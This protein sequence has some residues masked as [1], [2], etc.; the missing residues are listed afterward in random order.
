[1]AQHT[2]DLS[3]GHRGTA[4][5]FNAAADD[6]H[7]GYRRATVLATS[8]GQLAYPGFIPS[9]VQSPE[10]PHNPTG[11]S[12]KPTATENVGE[13]SSQSLQPAPAPST[14]TP[15]PA[16]L[17]Q[18][19]NRPAPTRSWQTEAPPPGSSRPLLF[20][21]LTRRTGTSYLNKAIWE[22]YSVRRDSASS[23]SS[24]GEED[25][26]GDGKR[27][28]ADQESR[29]DKWERLPLARAD[30]NKYRQ[31]SVGDNNYQTRGKV[32][33]DGRLRITV[34]ETANTGYLAKA[35]GAAM[36][37]VAPVSENDTSVPEI[38]LTDDAGNSSKPM[39]PPSIGPRPCLNIVIMVIGSRG[40]AQPFLKIGKVLK[41]EYGHRVRI[42][43]HPAFRDFV[44]KDSGLEF[45]SVGGDPSELMAF[46]VKNPGLIPTIDSVKAGD[47]GKRRAA[48][49]EMFGGF[50]RACIN[51]TDDEKDPHNLKMMGIKTPFVADAII[52][53]PP[54]FAHIHCAE[55]LGI[56]LHLMFTFPYTPTQAFPHPLASV[57]KSNID[58]GYTNFISYPLVEMM[59]WQGLGDLV[60]EFRVKTLRL[61]PMSTV[62]APGATYRLHV[63]FTYLWSPEL[64]PKPDDWGKEIGISGFVFLDLASSFEPPKDLEEFLG[65]GDKP[66]YIGFGSIVVDDPAAFTQ[67]IFKAV[68][69]AGVRALV[70]KGWGKLGDEDVPENIFM[71]DNTPHD[72]LFPRV[73]ACVIHGGA[74]TTAI[75]LKCGLPTMIVP[76]FGDQHFWG[77]M[78]G[79]AG[80][81]PDPTPYK[82]LD[83]E[84]L[85]AGIKY[86]LTNEAQEAAK[87]MATAI[88]NDGDGAFNAVEQFHRQLLAREPVN[89][90][91]SILKDHA[92][93]WTLKG[94]HVRL[95]PLA[96]DILVSK[97]LISWKRLRLIRHMEWND[98]QG[99]GE[100]VTG[101]ASSIA[102]SAGEAFTG[103]VSVP[104]RWTK[105]ATQRRGK[106]EAGDKNTSKQKSM[107]TGVTD[108]A[109]GVER[110]AAAIAKAPVDLSLALAQGFHNA[111][112][113]YGD[114]T[115][116]R[117]PRVT[118]FCS[119]LRAARF[120]LFYGIYDGFTGVVRLPVRGAKDSGATGFVKG[121]GM[122][123]TGLVLKNLSA[124]VGPVG[125]TLKGIV[126]QA[127]RR[128]SPEKFIRRA[129]IG[130][131]QREAREIP[132][133]QLKELI[134]QTVEGW[135]IL[136][137]LCD[138]IADVERE[139]GVAGQIDRVL[140][141]LDV[142][143]EDVDTARKALQ[144]LKDGESLESIANPEGRVRCCERTRKSTS[145][146]RSL[147]LPRKSREEPSR[148]SSHSSRETDSKRKGVEAGPNALAAHR[149][150][151]VPRG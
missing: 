55:A 51:A 128:K 61:D 98:F 14:T 91:C 58:P 109:R 149:D 134:Q 103:I 23:S 150:S 4:V 15:K 43:T 139:R 73:K 82:A 29:P 126:K 99:P 124:V 121:V 87:K 57:K 147:S 16:D 115:V 72:W 33:K 24:S 131:G 122:G 142:I 113:L 106:K 108:V 52:A 68:E 66:I 41:E 62:W 9:P 46:M 64:V 79:S 119:G 151:G 34:N 130:Q 67:M 26:G 105:K 10:T 117:T 114:D 69:M 123:L 116:R 63:P 20:Q 17:T 138:H 44:E 127:G 133:R 59:V 97:R 71:L 48:M 5:A 148:I 47:I 60:N 38:K 35:L 65:R 27:D 21:S 3:D 83:V 76:F 53:N 39:A 78:L 7:A 81:G 100:P 49:A 30:E 89:L 96:A 1:M 86:C 140:L 75:A 6:E 37:K 42:A 120:E 77:N 80:V 129:R 70:S 146:L 144:A 104:Y 95:S 136:K 132:E 141:D 18:I 74:G 118:G 88:E 111:P 40:D 12:S 22:G 143:F 54:S 13:Q 85:A 25:G 84:K 125:Y 50:W 31:F 110:T 92:A 94:S 2:Q 11:K 32:K 145:T 8:D 28:Q 56:P 102:R 101:V 19:G 90:R 107:E 137:D 135:L 45:F 112:R 93:V 36:K